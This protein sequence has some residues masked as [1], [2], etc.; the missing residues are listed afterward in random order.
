LEIDLEL[1]NVAPKLQSSR[2]VQFN[3]D[4]A[5][6][7]PLPSVS[8]RF[9]YI[10]GN[11]EVPT[12]SV[13]DRALYVADTLD[14][15][16]AWCEDVLVREIS[17]TED[18]NDPY[19]GISRPVHLRQL[20]SLCP[21]ESSETVDKLLSYFEPEKVSKGAVLWHQGDASTRAI[22][23]CEGKLTSSVQGE[24]SATEVVSVGYL[25]GEYGLINGQLR[26][27]TITA[28]E[29]SVIFSLR[30]EKFEKMLS[31]DPYLAFV[32]TKICSVRC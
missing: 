1:N 21:N 25:C 13:L 17:P 7:E 27:S 15:A 28:V 26:Q 23:L 20:H 8:D 32:L 19:H 4:G 29:P 14:D 22:L 10:A 16:L 2:Q 18:L 12:R 6:S 30:K 11:P 3:F 24:E 31:K 5:S 9:L